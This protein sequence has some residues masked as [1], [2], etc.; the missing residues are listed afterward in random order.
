MKN[1]KKENGAITIITLVS[2]LFLASFLISSY[3]LVANKVKTQKEMV[4][5]TR[6]IY[7]STSSMEEIYN[8]YFSNDNVIPIY[9]VEQL[10]LMGEEKDDV[11]INGKYYD[12]NNDENTIYMLMNDLKFKASDYND[13]LTD[14][15]WTPMGDN[16]ELKAKFE[17]KNHTIEVIYTDNENAEYSVIYL[18]DNKYSEPEYEVGVI[19]ELED[20]TIASTAKILLN[21]EDTGLIGSTKVKITRL[22][23]TTVSAY[24]DENYTSQ[25][26]SVLIVNPDKIDDI[27]VKLEKKSAT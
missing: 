13:Q 12:F 9:T 25:E 26:E 22:K 24:L 19:P 5:E 27:H 14:G 20:K 15:Y 18:E 4:N 10:L 8:S 2:I 16:T 21:N 1:L 11:N 17:G 6:E 7:E 3:I 23:K